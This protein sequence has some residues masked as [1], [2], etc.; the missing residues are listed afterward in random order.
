MT[1]KEQTFSF[2][3]FISVSRYLSHLT[4]ST[5]YLF[6]IPY[7]SCDTS[8]SGKLLNQVTVSTEFSKTVKKLLKNMWNINRVPKYMY[9]WSITLNWIFLNTH[10]LQKYPDIFIWTWYEVM[11]NIPKCAHFFICV[12]YFIYTNWCISAARDKNI[13]AG[14]LSKL[15]SAFQ[16]R[17]PYVKELT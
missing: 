9:P 16:R 10:Y 3:G 2:W 8:F 12:L 11:G 1:Q 15:Y 13:L 14:N 4:M 17:S 6:L 7:Y 5:D